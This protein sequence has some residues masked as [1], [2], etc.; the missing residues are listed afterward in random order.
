MKNLR[1][2]AG[3]LAILVLMAASLSLQHLHAQQITYQPYLQPGDHSGFSERDGMVVAWQTNEST[4]NA[5]AYSVQFGLTPAVSSTATVNGRVVDNYLAADPSLP[6]APTSVGPRV[7]Y[8]AVLPNL[9]YDR[10]YYY[11]VTGPGLPSQGFTAS[12][13]SRKRSSRFS[14]LVQGDEG[15]FPTEPGSSQLVADYEARIV[16]L[17]YNASKIS[18]PGEPALPQ[19]DI[20]LNTGDNVYNQGA[21][22]SYRDFWMPVWNSNVD[23]NETGAPLLRSIPF[24]IVAGNHDTGGNGDFVNLL[25]SDSAPRFGGQLDGGDALQYFNDY[26][27]PLNGPTGVDAQFIWNGNTG[28]PNG[29]YFSYKGKSYTSS[30]AIEAFRAS[31]SVDAGAGSKRQI[32]HM[33]NFSFDYGKAH[34]LFLDANPHLFNALVDYSPT[35]AYAP[36][37]FPDYPQVLR[38]W[39][40]ND[41]DGSN[42]TWKIVVFH[43]PAFSSGNSTLRNFQMRAIVKVLEDHGVNIVFN[44]HEHNYQRTHP[45][46]AVSNVA[47]TPSANNPAVAIDTNFDGIKNTVP[48]GVLYLVEGAGG[49]RDFDGNLPTPRGQGTGSVDQDDSATGNFT[50]GQYSFPQGPGSWLDTSLTTTEMT[51]FMA[52][53]GSGPKITQLFKA[54]VFSFADLVFDDNQFTLY[55]ISEPLTNQSSA[56]ASNPIPFGT[57]LYGKVL[58]DPIP[59]T[60]VDPTT[61]SVISAPATGTSALLDKFTVN[62][63]ELEGQVQV[64]LTNPKHAVPG[65]SVSYSVSVKN[66]SKFALNGSQLVFAMPEGATLAGNAG[67]KLTVQ[68]R[69]IVITIGRIESGSGT[70]VDVPVTLASSS[71]DPEGGQSKASATLRSSTALPISTD[72]DRE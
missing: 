44:G 59:D 68:G 39:V 23:S 65:Q 40:I 12:F 33:S 31:T 62:K 43:Q 46:R 63:P 52:G 47:A 60:L 32:D 7:N 36:V 35:S 5:A 66:N 27:F 22:G 61:G 30:A 45:L 34:F 17:M 3:R 19:P 29:F 58:N 1:K 15:F 26:Y 56:T 2:P 10:T 54:K 42:Q 11:R 24:Y 18:F 13:H 67:E 20:A 16:H 21:E 41:L 55:Q 49:N 38:D 9:E 14:V 71:A 70:S 37:A 53:A 48:D 57:D 69:N 25:A 28:T 50:S 64:K 6:V 72:S 8:T 51:P 4:P